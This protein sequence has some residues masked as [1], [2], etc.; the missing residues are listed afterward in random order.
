M[1]NLTT[2]GFS[3]LSY[4]QFERILKVSSFYLEILKK[5]LVYFKILLLQMFSFRHIAARQ[6]AYECVIL[7]L[8]R[9]ARVDMHNRAGVLPLDCVVGAPNDTYTAIKLNV[10]LRNLTLNVQKRAQKILTK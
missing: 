6:N 1:L 5:K 7:L 2:E 3:N 8:A 10:E 4:G 9:G